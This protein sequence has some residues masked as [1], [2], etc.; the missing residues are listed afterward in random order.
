MKVETQN[1][2]SYTQLMAKK[3]RLI[4][5]MISREIE[6]EILKICDIEERSKSWV[7]AAMIE[8]GLVAYRRDGQ[9]KEPGTSKLKVYVGKTQGKPEAKSKAGSR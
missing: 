8:R 9:L 4:G 1:L 7:T 5:A 6:D 3:D 2:E